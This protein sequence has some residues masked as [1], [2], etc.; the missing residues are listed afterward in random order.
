MANGVTHKSWFSERVRTATASGK[1][2]PPSRLSALKYYYEGSSSHI[3][4]NILPPRKLIAF[5][6]ESPG[7]PMSIRRQPQHWLFH[8][9]KLLWRP[10]NCSFAHRVESLS[11]LWQLLSSVAPC[12]RSICRRQRQRRAFSVSM[13]RRQIR[14]GMWRALPLFQ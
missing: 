3:S 1:F 2:G 8:T 4:R 13:V 10:S 12:S 7:V 6:T 11:K 14:S 5:I 9:A